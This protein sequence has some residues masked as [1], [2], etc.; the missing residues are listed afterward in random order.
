MQSLDQA[1]DA[2]EEEDVLFY[3]AFVANPHPQMVARLEHLIS[4]DVTIDEPLL[5]AYGAIVPRAS[6]ELQAR[7][8]TFLLDRLPMAELQ[9]S[10]LIHHIL[11]LG[12]TGSPTTFDSILDYLGHPDQGVQLTSILALRSLLNE[13]SVQNS[14]KDL[15]LDPDKTVAHVSMVAK[16]FLHGAEEASLSRQPRPYPTDLVQLL[17]AVAANTD[18]EEIHSTLTRYLRAVDTESS[19]NLLRFFDV[20]KSTNY[21]TTN[22]TRVR[23]GEQWDEDN[24]VYNLVAPLEERKADVL[25]YTHHFSYIWGKLFGG[26]DINMQI[27]AGGL[28]GV[29][30]DG[31]YKVFGHA[32]AQANLYNRHT[33]FLDFILLRKKSREE[34]ETKIYGNMMGKVLKNIDLH[35]EPEV[36]KTFNEPLYDGKVY[37]V[38]D[39]TY[40]VFVE[41]GTLDF[42]AKATVQFTAGLELAFCEGVGKLTAGAQLTPTLTLTVEASGDLEIVVSYNNKHTYRLNICLRVNLFV[43]S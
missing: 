21:Q 25:L 32:V 19:L 17:V 29:A 26:G 7:M 16:A 1:V 37:T 18:D 30:N 5:L 43:F 42:E 27:A 2:N 4:S 35:E 34:T 14:L 39:F 31:E 8:T 6:P 11:A 36:C 10:S 41:V 28:A 12:N 22:V 33:T 9:K 40:S 38:F 15:L 24:A 23:R 13:T 20:V 3:L